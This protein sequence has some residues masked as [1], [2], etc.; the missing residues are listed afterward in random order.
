MYKLYKS[1]PLSIQSRYLRLDENNI[2]KSI[3]ELDIFVNSPHM[4][5]INTL[6]FSK[7]VLFSH[8][9]R[10]N[11]CI[12]GY[13]DDVEV[14]NEVIR[15]SSGINDTDRKLRIL[16]LYKGYKYILKRNNI[17]KDTLKHLY[18]ILSNGLLSSGD[19]RYMGEYYREKPVY[20]YYSENVC[21]EPDQGVD[22]YN[23]DYYMNHLLDFI[24]SNNECLSKTELFVKS[25]ILH[26][27]FV[28]V[29]PYFD[30]NGRTS[31]T[32]SMWYLLNNKA[33]P[34]IIFN[35]AIQ[36]Y[37]PEYYKVIRDVKLYANITYF[38]NYMMKHVV[39]ELEKDYIMET[40]KNTSNEK[41]TSLDYQTL[42]Y[43]LSMKSQKTYLDFASLYNCH[44]D[45]KKITNIYHE[46]LLPLIDKEI[47]IPGRSTNKQISG[48]MN[49][50]FFTINPNLY[51]NDPDKIKCIKL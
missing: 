22:A 46:M 21:L 40:I 1:L 44:N 24:N 33:Y 36:L 11:N 39:E 13:R 35:R 10:A 42:H 50:H 3:E 6:K 38:I 17:D 31:R 45:K 25:Q 41:L 47:L 23:I 9:L 30:I 29:H 19:I 48:I 7:D 16:N 14:I 18:D 37:K 20:I 4:K 26:F 12:E 5:Y 15:K 8:E 34:F 49:N 51:D 28:Y 27:Y 32:T 43:I 2:R